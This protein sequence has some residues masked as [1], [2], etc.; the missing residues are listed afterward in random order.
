MNDTLKSV[1]Y[2]V[3]IVSSGRAQILRD[4]VEDVLAQTVAP[5][6]IILST[7]KQDD[8]V[9]QNGDDT[10]IRHIYGRRGI[11]MQLNAA[12]DTLSADVEYFIVF[13]DDVALPTDYCERALCWLIENADMIALD[14][15]FIRDGGINR[16]EADTLLHQDRISR[17]HSFKERN[18]LY[19]CNMCAR[20]IAFER[21]RFDEK[22]EGYAWL[23]DL[24]WALRLTRHGR[25]GRASDCRMVHLMA[26]SGRAPGYK[27]GYMQV[28]NP[29]Y[30]YRKG[31]L[32]VRELS[33]RFI[34]KHLAINL[35][36]TLSGDKKIDRW[37]RLRGNLFGLRDVFFRNPKRHAQD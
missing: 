13:D 17:P 4:T 30:L 16:L 36:K 29:Y 18:G 25:V 34:W 5:R 1:N 27:L 32:P 21:E 9:G 8:W 12:L 22:L 33:F 37:G 26:E 7:I 6:E 20:K 24:D 3:V 35:F 23:F 15:T 2:T 19:G 10:R 11:P 31:V 14:G 28:M